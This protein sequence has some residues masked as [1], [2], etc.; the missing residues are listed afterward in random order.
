M[1]VQLWLR[2]VGFAFSV[3]VISLGLD[4]LVFQPVMQYV[5]EFILVNNITESEITSGVIVL[6]MIPASIYFIR[7]LL[8]GKSAEKEDK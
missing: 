3:I 7:M 4:I 2:F 6:L 1:A 8:V 5:Q